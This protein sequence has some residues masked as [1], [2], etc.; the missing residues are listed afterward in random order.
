MRH[1]HYYGSD[2]E[3]EVDSIEDEVMERAAPTKEVAMEQSPTTGEEQEKHISR[4]LKLP[5][6]PKRSIRVGRAEPLVDYSQ[7]QML[8]SE[9]H[10]TTLENT[11]IQKERV[12]EMKEQKIKE[13]TIKKS[14]RVEELELNKLKREKSKEARRVAIELEA[15]EKALKKIQE[16]KNK[17]MY[18]IQNFEVT[19]GNLLW[20]LLY[21]SSCLVQ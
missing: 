15:A 12:Q 19:M 10:L 9:E 17:F 21:R 13:R 7:L 4:F 5:K 16:E 14:K 8:T 18:L 6:A 20:D 1:T 3:F 11:T 2:E